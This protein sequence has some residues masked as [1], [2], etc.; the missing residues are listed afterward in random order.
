VSSRW[1]SLLY[2][3]ST[4]R[5]Y[6]TPSSRASVTTVARVGDE[7][8]VVAWHWCGPTACWRDVV[9]VRPGASHLARCLL[10]TFSEGA[11]PL[12]G[13]AAVAGAPLLA[14]VKGVLPVVLWDLI[15]LAG[16]VWRRTSPWGCARMLD[17]WSL[18]RATLKDVL[19][20]SRILSVCFHNWC[21]MVHLQ[22]PMENHMLHMLDWMAEARE[23]GEAL[24]R[25]G[26]YFIF[27]SVRCKGK[28]NIMIIQ[29][30][31]Y[32]KSEACKKWMHILDL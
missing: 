28:Y 2:L 26:F 11:E 14:Y 20:L 18:M 32:K 5:T 24:P 25:R 29:F 6:P 17:A 13:R 31:S 27:F 23:R 9:V 3:S 30:L 22:S 4:A 19:P 7:V 12:V 16:V 8:A 10:P 15:S 1:S 21:A